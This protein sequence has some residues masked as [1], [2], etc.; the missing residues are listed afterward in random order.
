MHSTRAAALHRR[1]LHASG[2][3]P[4]AFVSAARHWLAEGREDEVEQALSFLAAQGRRP[5]SDD[6]PIRYAMAPAGPDGR[7]RPA[8][9]G[10][11]L[12]GKRN[13][14]DGLDRIDLAAVT[15]L[16]AWP[17]AAG[18][19]R[20]WRYPAPATPYPPPKRMF[21]VQSAAD[22]IGVAAGV[23]AALAEAGEEDPL[24]EVFGEVDDLPALQRRALAG[25]GLLWSASPVAPIEIVPTFDTVDERGRPSFSS[26]RVTL[27]DD[28]TD[29]VVAYLAAG[30]PL[31]V[32]P[33]LAADVLDPD[34]RVVPMGI[35]G[36]GRWLWSE[37]VTYYADEYGIAPDPRLLASI[38]EA[39]YVVPE[40]DPVTMHRSVS[41]ILTVVHEFEEVGGRD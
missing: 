15:A 8:P 1:L 16:T 25:S 2:R 33:E 26:E 9:Y 20:C 22:P 18:L 23:Q 5:P 27:D 24:V 6:D 17:A 11:D 28:E 38:R 13:D 21:L 12:T 19:W 10:V 37:A 35:R 36:D 7:A 30:T 41:L 32:S 31:L 29:R 34:A 40:V 14:L 4:D 39:D 3:A